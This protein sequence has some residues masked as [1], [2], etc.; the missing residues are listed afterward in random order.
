MLKCKVPII[1]IF[2]IE[3]SLID[4]IG[5]VNM[6]N[7][8]SYIIEDN[9][10][11]CDNCSIEY[12][13]DECGKLFIYHEVIDSIVGALEAR[14][15]YTANHSRRV[16]DLTERLCLCLNLTHEERELIHIAAHVHDIGKI[17][18]PD[19]VL[20][21]KGK[22]TE[23]E[24]IIMKS[25]SSIGAKILSKSQILKP[26]VNIVLYHHERY[27]GRGYPEGLKGENIPLGARILAVCDSIDA[28]LSRRVYRKELTY[29]QCICE[30]EKN[31]GIMYDPYIAQCTIDNWDS[32]VLDEMYRS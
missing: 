16:S 23:E 13:N 17:G 5:G 19:Q 18:I 6:K 28:M 20:L 10:D 2:Y 4:V 11:S 12:K 15:E 22:L 3:S 14:D 24:W 32:I 7:I 8:S 9:R 1:D 21:K 25:H 30:I 29:E 31:K 27:D 26:L